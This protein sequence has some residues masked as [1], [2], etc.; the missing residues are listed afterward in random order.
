MSPHLPSQCLKDIAAQRANANDD[1]AKSS[2]AKRRKSILSEP[3]ILVDGPVDRL[4]IRN[5]KSR[6]IKAKKFFEAE[7]Q[8]SE[9]EDGSEDDENIQL[10]KRGENQAAGKHS[11]KP[12][13]A[14]L[15]EIIESD[16][17]DAMD[18]KSEAESTEEDCGSEQ[19]GAGDK[20]RTREIR[21]QR[22]VKLAQERLVASEQSDIVSDDET[23]SHVS[24]D[25]YSE[26]EMNAD[27]H[28]IVDDNVTTENGIVETI[29]SLI[30]NNIIEMVEVVGERRTIDQP[31]DN[32]HSDQLLN[33]ETIDQLVAEEIPIEY[34]ITDEK[35]IN[36][37]SMPVTNR[38]DKSHEVKTKQTRLKS[39][40][41]YE[42]NKV[43]CDI[44][45]EAMPKNHLLSHIRFVHH[46]VR[47]SS[48]CECDVCGYVCSS[49]SNLKQHRR[50]H[51]EDNQKPF[52]CNYCGK[53][54]NGRF[55]LNEH[56]NV[57]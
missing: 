1:Q 23:H 38:N 46:G 30:S 10:D 35:L 26:R 17:S 3:N 9:D 39:P 7:F 28:E 37:L 56:I 51:C 4:R 6:L 55:H 8:D 40:Y 57:Q 14:F 11:T 45:S 19:N 16:E 24:N 52:I 12:M 41:Y 50:R 36:N 31:T 54:F 18:V 2:D 33:I 29:R 43:F 15:F 53:G 42:R 13:S 34:V 21:N 49:K 20:R 25:E 27:V 22:A 48:D 44:C 47:T 32:R 5:R